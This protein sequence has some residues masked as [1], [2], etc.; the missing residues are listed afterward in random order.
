MCLGGLKKHF[1]CLL[2][3][4]VVR[5]FCVVLCVSFCTGHFVMVPLNL[6]YIHCLQHSFFEYLFN[7]YQSLHFLAR[8]GSLNTTCSSWTGLILL[9]KHKFKKVASCHANKYYNII[10]IYHH[11]NKRALRTLTTLDRL[12][13]PG[14]ITGAYL[15]TNYESLGPMASDKKS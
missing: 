12:P 15:Y 7:L 2:R 11:Y 5:V 6:T 4:G 8:W 13:E 10:D 3:N 14:L 9:L 1:K